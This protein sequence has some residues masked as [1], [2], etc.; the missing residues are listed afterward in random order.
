MVC[1]VSLLVSFVVLP[2]EKTSRHY[3]TVCFIIAVC[4]LQVH[5]SR[6]LGLIC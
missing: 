2:V 3:L 5:L 6:L 4:I 1:T